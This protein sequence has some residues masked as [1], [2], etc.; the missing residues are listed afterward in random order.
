[1]N[2]RK[3]MAKVVRA[4]VSDLGRSAEAEEK[5][6][7]PK[8]GIW[9]G[10]VLFGAIFVT[11]L[12]LIFASPPW[13][14]ILLSLATLYFL[15]ALYV[16]R[17]PEAAILFA[18]GVAVREVR[19]GWWLTLP[20]LHNLSVETTAKQ[21]LHEAEREK[22][23]QELYYKDGDRRISITVY[24]RVFFKLVDVWEA[25]RT[26]G[27]LNTVASRN[28]IHSTSLSSLRAVLGKSSFGKLLT[29]ERNLEEEVRDFTNAK[30]QESG[31][32]V[33]DVDIYDYDERVQ[34]EASRI[35][36][37]AD[38]KAYEA[39]KMTAAVAKPL[40]G[41]Y[42]AAIVASVSTL[43]TT[44]REINQMRLEAQRRGRKERGESSEEPSTA[45]ASATLGALGKI[46][47]RK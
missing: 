27:G 1:M 41:N 2:V 45:E 47:G 15:T 23:K 17:E 44:A 20:F 21:I 7:L 14:L 29:D 19:P 18:L 4:V 31:Y 43:A 39:E 24:I 10:W 13:G 22:E 40:E 25:L 5:K 35:T 46:L 32:V 3:K 12:I 6:E 34:S 26:Y 42:P 33:V 28:D 36:T 38:A 16:I 8:G 37:I 30:L 11:A 9:S